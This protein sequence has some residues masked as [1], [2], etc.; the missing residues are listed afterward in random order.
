M[1]SSAGGDANGSVAA[2]AAEGAT[3]PA[4]ADGDATAVPS[5]GDS[6]VSSGAIDVEQV[7]ALEP[8]LVVRGGC[9]R[10]D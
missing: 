8:E 3:V 4:A 1:V 9:C 10:H 2:V 7:V 5:A 6:S